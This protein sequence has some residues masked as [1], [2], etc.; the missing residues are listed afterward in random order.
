[1]KRDDRTE[2]SLTF[3]VLEIIPRKG[4][5]RQPLRLKAMASLHVVAVVAVLLYFGTLYKAAP[6][7]A[8]TRTF[9]LG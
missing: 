9:F 8:H 6:A 1:M 3:E 5:E 7:S 2:I 4:K